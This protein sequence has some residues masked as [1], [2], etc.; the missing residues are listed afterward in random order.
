MR[1]LIALL[2]CL[3]MSVCMLAMPV[4]A[5][6]PDGPI[7]EDSQVVVTDGSYTVSPTATSKG[8]YYVE[9]L[10]F[11][12]IYS[13]NVTPEKGARLN[14]WLKNDNPVIITVYKTN[15]F[16]LYSKVY[17]STQFNAGTRDI[18]VEENCNGSKYLI[19]CQSAI[20]GSIMSLLAYQ[21]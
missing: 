4:S 3:T 21:N 1:K 9:D 13:F 19:K 5:A 20:D 10:W 2:C 18:I 15:I 7:V 17:G 6:E 14:I 12:D 8:L 16:G 11:I